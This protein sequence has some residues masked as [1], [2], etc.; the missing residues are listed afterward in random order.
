MRETDPFLE[1][2]VCSGFGVPGVDWRV[3]KG[4]IKNGIG[5]YRHKF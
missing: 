3:G 4:W 5:F 2:S 1:G